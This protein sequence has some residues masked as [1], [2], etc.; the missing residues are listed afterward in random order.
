MKHVRLRR[1]L[2]VSFAATAAVLFGLAC[3]GQEPDRN[4]EAVTRV[5]AW[6]GVRASAPIPPEMHQKNNAGGRCVIASVVTAGRYQGLPRAFT[7]R[8]WEKSGVGGYSPGRLERLIADVNRELGTNVQW[9]SYYGP[10]KAEVLD[11]LSREGYPMGV[12]L[13][14]ADYA[15]NMHHMVTDIEFRTGGLSCL[16]DNNR[17]GVYRWMP[18]SRRLQLAADGGAIWVFAW[19][20]IPPSVRVAAFS[21]LLVT[22]VLLVLAATTAVGGYGA[23][24][25]LESPE[26]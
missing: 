4:G 3:M 16:V 9:T 20:Q 14:Q 19:S 25:L 13:T 1:V 7:E 26:P 6:Q 22:A 2:V 10:P 23:S 15:R 12:T 11:A 17:T 24:L 5:P 18:A 21:L 8:L